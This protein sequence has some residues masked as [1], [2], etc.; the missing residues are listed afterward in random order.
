MKKPR[1]PTPV[2]TQI[3]SAL[4][5]IWMYSSLRRQVLARA[6]KARG[7]YQCEQCLKFVTN[8]EIEV[9]HIVSATP[10]E[11]IIDNDWGPFIKRLL[12]VPLDGLIALCTTCHEAK[13]AIDREASKKAKKALKEKLLINNKKD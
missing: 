11:G 5:R 3:R 1:K 8:K 4:R 12:Y 6:R 7:I 13:T 9:D 2:S 10:P